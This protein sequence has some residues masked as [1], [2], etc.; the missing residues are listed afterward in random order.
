VI[1]VTPSGHPAWLPD[2]AVPGP[3]ARPATVTA[4]FALLVISS[5]LLL[6]PLVAMFYE[7]THF[8]AVLRRAADRTAA[9]PREVGQEHAA[10]Q[11]TGWTAASA[12]VLMSIAMFVPALWLGRGSPVGRL[13]S[14]AASG[15]ATLCC[16]T[17]IG[18]ATVTGQGSST[19]SPLQSEATRLSRQETPG[20]VSLTVLPVLLVPLLAITVLVLLLLP[21][22]NRFFRP[23]PVPQSPPYAYGGYY[24]YPAPPWEGP[25]PGA[26]PPGRPADPRPG[27]RP[28]GGSPSGPPSD[29][30]RPPA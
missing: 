30:P 9:S 12:L 26:V 10:N 7:L 20:W 8:D 6:L 5:A 22:S 19:R 21:S 18:L 25:P 3:R 15:V 28:P 11:L 27:I 2:A 17:G 24:A 16:C 23:P 1:D 14:S 29:D 13:L 4:A